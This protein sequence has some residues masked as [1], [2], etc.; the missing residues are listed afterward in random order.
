[1]T[2]GRGKLVSSRTLEETLAPETYELQDICLGKQQATCI[3]WPQTPLR[4]GP[5]WSPVSHITCP[6]SALCGVVLSGEP[7]YQNKVLCRPWLA[8]PSVCILYSSF[9]VNRVTSL[10]CDIPSSNRNLSKPR[11]VCLSQ[12]KF[13]THCYHVG[14]QDPFPVYLCENIPLLC[15]LVKINKGR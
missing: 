11:E 12:G 5:I 3:I 14:R 8:W 1:M 2:R 13:L 10:A 4:S 15:S 7:V 6:K 9:K